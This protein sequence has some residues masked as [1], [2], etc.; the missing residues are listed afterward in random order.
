MTR[1]T[2]TCIVLVHYG[3]P[4]I[5]K[6]CLDSLTRLTVTPHVVISNNDSEAC[7]R[8]LRDHVKALGSSI[9][10]EVVQNP[11]NKGFAAGCNVGIRRALDMGA[12][13]VWL[14]NNDTEVE[15]E[16]L[17]ALSR[18]AATNPQAIIGS[19]VVEMHAPEVVQV[20]GGVTYNAWTTVIAPAHAGR[21]R[22][23]AQILEPPQMDYVYGASFFIPIQCVEDIGGLDE[24]FFLYYEELDYCTRAKKAGY[25]LAWC[26]ESV[27]QHQGGAAAGSKTGER[28]TPSRLAAYH[29][30]RSVILFTRKHHRGKLLPVL[31]GRI[32]GKLLFLTIRRQ[33]GLFHPTI[34]GLSNGVRAKTKQDGL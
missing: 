28:E 15:P 6:R 34:A 9:R 29:E 24:T 5:T 31:L 33:W 2:A 17:E 23:D 4:E 26:R 16:A 22:A 14:L 32:L 11:G 13:H 3:D 30:S 21:D 20:A 19:T 27:V 8:L 10:A 7:G 12:D 1:E 18:Y 25:R